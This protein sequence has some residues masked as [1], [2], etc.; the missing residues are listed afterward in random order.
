M[1]QIFLG[2]LIFI[3]SIFSFYNIEAHNLINTT[4]KDKSDFDECI[5]KSERYLNYKF[6]D[7]EV[8]FCSNDREYKAILLEQNILSKKEIEYLVINSY[9][10]GFWDT[11]KIIINTSGLSKYKKKEIICH[12]LVHKYQQSIYS[13]EYLVKNRNKIEED[14]EYSASKINKVRY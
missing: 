2:L 8:Y 4:D 10:C 1:K 9:A 5:I 14:A 13:L 6:D 3:S 7:L 12:E 11:N